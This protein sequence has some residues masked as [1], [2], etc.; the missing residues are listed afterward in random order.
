ML[1][2]WCDFGFTVLLAFAVYILIEAPF[3][4]LEGLLLP[5]KRPCP[6][7]PAVEESKEA[8]VGGCSASAPTLENKTPLPA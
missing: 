7:R 2:F 6:P 8:P 1:R 4:N 3:G 5:D